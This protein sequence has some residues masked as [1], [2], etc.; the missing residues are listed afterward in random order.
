MELVAV[1]LSHRTA[2]V[3]LRERAA[4]PADEIEEIL[5]RND[6]PTAL[7]ER[8]LLSTCNRSELYA[9][10][11]EPE[12]ARRHFLELVRERRGV[13]PD[14]LADCLYLHAGRDM[15]QHLFRVASSVDSQVVGEAQIL[16][17]VHEAFALATRAGAAGPL[18][19][20]LLSS[21][22]RVGK[23]V[24]RE[25]DIAIGAVSVPY[26]AVTLATRI[27]SD[28]GDHTALLVGT[29]ETGE[30]AARHLREQG[31]G[32]LLVASRTLRNAV[33]LAAELGGASVPLSGLG[34]ALERSSLVITATAATEP[35]ITADL[36]RQAEADRRNR[37]LLIVDIG[38]PRDVEPAVRDIPNVFLY[39]IDSLQEL[40]AENLE[41]RRQEI[42]KVEAIVTH[43]TEKFFA[44]YSAL[45]VAPVIKELRDRFEVIRASEV[46]RFSPRFREDEHEQLE[47][48]TRAIVNKLLH[49]PMLSIRGFQRQGGNVLGR[50]DTVRRLFGLSGGDSDEEDER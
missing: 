9:L 44:W 18:L 14:E 13:E 8:L 30:L 41:R 39:D 27:F 35:V 37:P 15:A 24:R 33:S 26:A 1:G 12:L 42:P 36:V 5:R 3:A 11:E 16:G 10:A 34:T 38:V 17:Q 48:L 20:R 45:S 6:S 21:A 28:L 19:H 49:E 46:E 47:R 4:F 7:P 23:R 40:V 29:G 22:F 43:E 31:V 2:P 25:T 50:L 32:G